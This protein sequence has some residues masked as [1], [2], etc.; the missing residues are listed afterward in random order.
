MTRNGRAG[1]LLQDPGRYLV[2]ETVLDEVALAVGGNTGRAGVE[3]RALR[4]GRARRPSPRDL[5]SGEREQQVAAVAVAE[6]DLLVLDEPTREGL[7][8]D[9]EGGACRVAR[10]LRDRGPRRP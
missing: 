6:P 7:D 8:P 1:Y 5:S 4:P 2:C 9:R 10:C 3:L